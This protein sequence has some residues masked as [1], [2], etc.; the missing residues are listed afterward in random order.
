MNKPIFEN[1]KDIYRFFLDIGFIF[2]TSPYDTFFSG[3]LK[4]TIENAKEK[5]YIKKSV[6][7]E[8]REKY[9]DAEDLMYCAE[10]DLTNL[11]VICIINYVDLLEKEIERLKNE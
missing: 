10:D 6:L 5:G 9:K 3:T 8:A 4:N 11:D 2:E 7:E 1:E